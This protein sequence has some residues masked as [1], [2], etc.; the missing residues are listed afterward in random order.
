MP[1]LRMLE[2]HEITDPEIRERIRLAAD[3]WKF[4]RVKITIVGAAGVPFTGGR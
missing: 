3:E 1:N 4:T 2:L